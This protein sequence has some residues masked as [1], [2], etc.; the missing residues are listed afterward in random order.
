M[1]NGTEGN[2]EKK[3]EDGGEQCESHG[4]DES[5]RHWW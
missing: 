3:Y 2:A 4:E 5:A 1:N